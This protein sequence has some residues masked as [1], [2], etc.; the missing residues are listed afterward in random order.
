MDR[1]D[2][3]MNEKV[4]YGQQIKNLELKALQAQINP[5]FLYN[6]LDLINC[7]AISHS[8]P[9]ISRM[10]K[11]LGQFYRLSLSGGNERI[12]YLLR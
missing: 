9:Q 4:L 2:Q 7:T 5:H 3:L 12:P 10:V 1:I 11:A 8:V 6:S